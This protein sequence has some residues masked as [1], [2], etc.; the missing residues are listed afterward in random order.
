MA[1][2]TRGKRKNQICTLV[3]WC[4]D[5]F[6]VDT[7]DEQGVVVNPTSLV[8]DAAEVERVRR[9]RDEGGTGIMFDLFALSDDGRFTKAKSMHEVRMEI[10]ARRGQ[11]GN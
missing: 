5:W 9:N 2:I 1:T 8:L 6:I 3:Q 11:P 4:N 10:I 7:P